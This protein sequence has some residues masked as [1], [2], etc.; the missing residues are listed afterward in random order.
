[1][2]MTTQVTDSANVQLEQC[3]FQFQQLLAEKDEIIAHHEAVIARQETELKRLTAQQEVT[4]TQIAQQQEHA[5]MDAELAHRARAACTKEL[6]QLK[7]GVEALGLDPKEPYAFSEIATRHRGRCTFQ[8][9]S[10]SAWTRLVSEAVV[11]ASPIIDLTL[12]LPPHPDDSD[13]RW[14]HHL[15]PKRPVVDSVDV[16][17]SSPGCGAQRFHADAGSTH[18]KLAQRENAP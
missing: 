11:A 12:T 8:S 5:G 17:V 18:L 2:T 3:R 6:A 10:P 4:A 16:I 14:A 9:S 1:M 13:L 15:L 7:L